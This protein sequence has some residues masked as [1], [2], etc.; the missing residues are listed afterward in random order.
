MQGFWTTIVG[1]GAVFAYLSIFILFV[2]ACF[3]VFAKGSTK[4]FFPKLIDQRSKKKRQAI[5]QYIKHVGPALRDRYGVR[6][7]YRPTQVKNTIRAG[8]YASDFDCYALAMFCDRE[9]FTIYHES[10]G[11]T[12]DYDVMRGEV[13]NSFDCSFQSGTDFDASS[14]IDFSAQIDTVVDTQDSTSMWSGDNSYSSSSDSNSSSSGSDYSS[15]S[16][17]YS[18][19]GGDY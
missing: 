8:G 10:I 11:E 7:N 2:W 12:C 4:S 17:D 18:G 6:K 9:D 3:R 16:S 5:R 14:M 19:G 15:G 13:T 1:L